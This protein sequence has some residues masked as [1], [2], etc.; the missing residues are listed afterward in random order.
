MKS[1][2]LTERQV[3]RSQILSQFNFRIECRSGKQAVR[4]DA[5]SRRSQ[6]IPIN[7]DDP[8]LTER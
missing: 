3:R 4:P 5:L 8:R 6:V 2:K 7:V 1:R